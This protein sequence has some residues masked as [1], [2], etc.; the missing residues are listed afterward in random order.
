MRLRSF[1]RR[2]VNSEVIVLVAAIFVVLR[3]RFVGPPVCHFVFDLLSTHQQLVAVGTLLC[4]WLLGHI[5]TGGTVLIRMSMLQGIGFCSAFKVNAI[6][7][8]LDFPG[9]S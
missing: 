7:L 8:E 2:E 1:I 6:D 9:V 5:G 4:R 3:N